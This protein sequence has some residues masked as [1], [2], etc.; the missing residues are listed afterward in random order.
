MNELLNIAGPQSFLP[1]QREQVR[2]SIESLE[3]AMLKGIEEGVF[4]PLPM[5]GTDEGSAECDH[6]FGD[7]VYV[8]SLWIKAGS[9]VVGRLH[10]QARVCMI[11][12][13]RCRFVD[14]FQAQVVEAPWIG[15][16]HAGCK[17]AVYAET[18]TLWAACLG[19]DIKDP[20]T[21]FFE[22]TASSH[23]ELLL[24]QKQ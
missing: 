22:L 20:Q 19:T 13:G 16:F 3:D 7:G 8:R 12:A 14:E 15:E 4:E 23:D 1:A 9:V 5:G 6:Y 10:K 24:E 11:L 21:A 17:T 18:D 2:A